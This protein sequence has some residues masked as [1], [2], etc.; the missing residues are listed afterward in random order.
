VW[1]SESDRIS[2]KF[3]TV[4]SSTQTQSI[5]SIR[6]KKGTMNTMTAPTESAPAAIPTR[7]YQILLADDHPLFR[8]GVAN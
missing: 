6:F 4:E 1:N 3:L 7:K 5:D 8:R 2:V